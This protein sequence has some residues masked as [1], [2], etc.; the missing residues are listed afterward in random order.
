MLE[1]VDEVHTLTSLSG[2]K[3]CFVGRASPVT[4]SHSIRDGD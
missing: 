4:D 2:L 3:R 1:E